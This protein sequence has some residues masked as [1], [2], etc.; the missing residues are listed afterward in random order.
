[1]TVRP[2]SSSPLRGAATRTAA[3]SNP[4][5][6]KV[7]IAPARGSN[8][9]LKCPSGNPPACHHRPCEGQQHSGPLLLDVAWMPVII[10]PA[11]GSN[12][13]ISAVTAYGMR[14]HHRPCE[15][16]QP[17][18]R[19]ADHGGVPRVI[20]APARGSNKVAP[21]T[22]LPRR[23]SHHRPCEGQ[24]QGRT[25]DAVAAQVQ[26]SSPLRGAATCRRL[27]R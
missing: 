17:E 26:S 11:R 8:L 4:T 19:P 20:I 23:S 13:T 14:R 18:G 22:L 3:C 12:N 25:L 1:M 2:A 7:I 10:A 9:F 6:G 27:R 5:E 24:Q 15:G 16:Q 21:S